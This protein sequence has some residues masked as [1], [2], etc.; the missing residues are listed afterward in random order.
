MQT[1]IVPEKYNLKK[2]NTFILDTFPLLHQNALYKALRQKDI[3]INNIKVSDNKT[4]HT[5]DIVTIYITDSIL[6]GES[7]LKYITI[8]SSTFLLN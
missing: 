5:H 6:F 7:F 4:L 3:R 1:L 2:L 8:K